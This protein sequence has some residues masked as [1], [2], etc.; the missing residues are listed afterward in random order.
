MSI[1]KQ[2][3]NFMVEFL[4]TLIMLVFY[5]TAC[6]V[7]EIMDLIKQVYHNYKKSYKIN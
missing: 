1:L 3:L 6:V 2:F 5:M 7:E 4:L